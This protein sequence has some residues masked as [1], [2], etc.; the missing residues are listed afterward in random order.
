M[1]IVGRA[2]LLLPRNLYKRLERHYYRMFNYRM[3]A[4]AHSVICDQGFGKRGTLLLHSTF[5]YSRHIQYDVTGIDNR[6]QDI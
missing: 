2:N 6:E 1:R 4:V 3:V 5:V